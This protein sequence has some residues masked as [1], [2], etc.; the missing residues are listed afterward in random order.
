MLLGNTQRP[1]DR[2]G[3]F[4]DPER[5][6]LDLATDSSINAHNTIVSGS[7]TI[8]SDRATPGA[9]FTHTLGR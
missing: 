8:L 5:R 9:G 1:G 7:A 4:L 2:G 3:V 6:T